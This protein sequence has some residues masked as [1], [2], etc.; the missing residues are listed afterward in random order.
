MSPII[1][2][3][4]AAANDASRHIVFDRKFDQ[5]IAGM[6]CAALP[7]TLSNTKNGSF[8]KTMLATLLDFISRDAAK[9]RIVEF[10]HEDQTAH[11]T[12]HADSSATLSIR[13]SSGLDA[14]VASPLRIV[15]SGILGS[16]IDALIDE[17]RH[18]LCDATE[19]PPAR[20]ISRSRLPRNLMAPWCDAEDDAPVAPETQALLRDAAISASAILKPISPTIFRATLIGRR[21]NSDGS[22]DPVRVQITHA[23]R[24]KEASH[25]TDPDM[26]EDITRAA[27]STLSRY[28]G[29]IA[30]EWDRD[31]A[32]P[33][34]LHA[35]QI[36][37]AEVD[38]C[39]I[40]SHDIIESFGRLA[41]A[42]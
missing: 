41:S 18:W 30:Q 32:S 25:V 16:G 24:N 38:S 37:H 3:P 21:F 15:Q 12:I 40:S 28:D 23:D 31:P 11:L 1:E 17:C 9:S 14:V 2:F 39:E 6:V 36:C 7:V 20:W 5:S 13:Q 42:C 4:L 26:F 22:L 35:A 19:L 33:S 29:F 27:V 8:R 34:R 10:K